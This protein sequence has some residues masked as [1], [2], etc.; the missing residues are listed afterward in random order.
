MAVVRSLLSHSDLLSALNDNWKCDC[1]DQHNLFLHPRQPADDADF[2]FDLASTD[3]SP[4][5]QVRT[6]ETPLDSQQ[7]DARNGTNGIS[8][9]S[10]GLQLGP[11]KSSQLTLVN[12]VSKVS[13]TSVSRTK[14]TF[15][16]A[17][18]TTVSVKT[19]V[20]DSGEINDLRQLF[21]T[22]Q[23][24]KSG[25]LAG[26]IKPKSTPVARHD[27]FFA[28]KNAS[29]SKAIPVGAACCNSM[30]CSQRNGITYD[31]DNTDRLSLAANLA[32]N[33]FL[34]QG[35]WLGSSWSTDKFVIPCHSTDHPIVEEIHLAH[36]SKTVK[37]TANSINEPE[38]H[39]ESLGMALVEIL[40]GRHLPTPSTPKQPRLPQQ[41]TNIQPA[42][43]FDAIQ[44]LY[45]TY[46]RQPNSIGNAVR[47]CISWSG[48]VSKKGFDDPDFSSA[49]YEKVV[50]PLIENARIF[51]GK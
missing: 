5:Y 38:R 47:E 1:V 19:F 25:D 30:D 2:E 7:K 14:V 36:D 48:P 39:L 9:Q 18:A 24:G 37:P 23:T 42:P 49:A 43:I 6:V 15:K 44:K 32:R 31:L 28:S 11:T 46:G 50:W 16:D 4:A 33:T 21:C 34:L 20:D 10:R 27:L 8:T 40:L 35:T 22:V 13:A 3:S 29:F 17:S 41:C 12:T 51:E 45:K 26:F